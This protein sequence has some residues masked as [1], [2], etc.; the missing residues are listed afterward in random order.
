MN[1]S[2][3]LLVAGAAL[4]G[5]IFVAACVFVFV[6]GAYRPP[7]SPTATP[8]A[9]AAGP[10]ATRRAL[11]SPVALEPTATTTPGAATAAPTADAPAPGGDA[12]R[13]RVIFSAGHGQAPPCSGCHATVKV[14]R[15]FAIGPNLSGVADRAGTRVQGLS[16]EA[17]LTQSIVQPRVFVVPGFRDM[18]YAGYAEAFSAADVADVVAYLMTLHADVAS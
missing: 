18:M 13:G 16:A 12:E 14:G 2:T 4:G 3:Y 6:A 9:V 7:V 1:R 11:P 5:V 10:T 15:G 17:Y 8:R